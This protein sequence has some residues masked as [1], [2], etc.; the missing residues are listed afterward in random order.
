MRPHHLFPFFLRRGRHRSAFLSVGSTHSKPNR[1]NTSFS[2][3]GK[4]SFVSRKRV[5]SG[6]AVRND[7]RHH[8]RVNGATYIP[9]LS[10]FMAH[11]SFAHLRMSRS[12]MMEPVLRC[13]P[14]Q[15]QCLVN[16]MSCVKCNLPPKNGGPI[17]LG[18][19]EDEVDPPPYTAM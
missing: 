3:L 13:V 1:W 19:R 6:Q 5:L 8:S 10:N 7:T 18:W 9:E 16:A 12:N 2:V 15:A 14:S 17:Y 4:N 11:L